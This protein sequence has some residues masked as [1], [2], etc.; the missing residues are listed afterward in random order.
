M[1]P[2]ALSVVDAARDLGIALESVRTFRR[3][4]LNRDRQPR[5][6]EPDALSARSWPTTPSSRSSRARCPLEHLTLGTPYTF[7]LVTRAAARP[8]RRRPGAAE[9]ARASLS[10]S[11]AEMQ[12]IQAHFR[13]WAA[14]RPTS[15]WRRWPRPGREH[16][17]HKTLKGRIDFD[18]RRIDN[19]LKETIFGATQEIRRRL[20]RRRLVRQRLRG[21]RRRRPLRRPATTSASRSRRTTIPRPSSPTAAPTPAW[22]A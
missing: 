22:A 14:T 7:Q 1:D 19:L 20:G 3:Y 2:V 16:C 11:L 6:R 4:F 9:P 18:G 21:Q 15:S 5:R 10:L 17:S 12:A 13:A 8:G